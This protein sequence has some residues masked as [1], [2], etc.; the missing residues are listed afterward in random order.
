M[1]IARVF[2][3]TCFR[4]GRAAVA[5]AVCVL[6][7]CAMFAAP[8]RAQCT[9]GWLPGEGFPGISGGIVECS[10]MWDPD[11]PGPQQPRLV[12]AGIFAYAGNALG[13]G[14]AQW[15]P[16]TGVWSTLGPGFSP[17][18]GG[19]NPHAIAAGANGELYVGGWLVIPGGGVPYVARWTGSGWVQLGGA[20]DGLV[21]AVMVMP[22]GDVVVGG[23]FLNAGGVPARHVARW[24]GSTWSGLGAGV[25][26]RVSA[27]ASLPNGDIIVGGLFSN[28]GGVPASNIA[29]WNGVS[30]S[31]LGTGMV[32][33]N[34]NGG[35][36]VLALMVAAGGDIIAGGNFTTAGGAPTLNIAR[37]NG[38][39]WSQ[40]GVGLDGPVR[41]LLTLPNSHIIAGGTFV[42][43]VG[44]LPASNI[45]EWNPT[46]NSW[47]ALY[48]GV[49]STVYTVTKLPSGNVFAGGQ[50]DH[51]GIGVAV[52][53]A[54]WN[55]SA[56]SAMAGGMTYPSEVDCLLTA[57]SGDVLVGGAFVHAGNLDANRVASFNGVS[58]GAAQPAMNER[59]RAFCQRPNGDFIVGGEF[60]SAGNATV[61]RIARWNGSG[62]VDMNGGMT[63]FFQNTTPIVDAL[64][65][66]PNGDVYA[67]GDF[68]VAGGIL[69]YFLARWDGTS[70]STPGGGMDGI[71]RALLVMPNGDLIVGGDFTN[72]G[73]FGTP[74]SAPYLARWNGSVWS[75]VGG[76]TGGP[77]YALA[78]KPNGDIAVGGSFTSAGG[79]PGYNN[80][81]IW[82]GT[83]W[84]PLSSGTDTTVHALA[85]RANG[86]VIA[87]GDFTTAG[88]A[89]A[90]YIARYTGPG[91]GWTSLGSP[92]AGTNGSVLAL[93]MM[94]NGDVALGGQFY[95]VGGVGL[96]VFAGG[97]VSTYFARYAFGLDPLVIATQPVGGTICH[98]GTANLSVALAPG[99]YGAVSYQWWRY[100]NA[101]P[102]FSPI[103]NGVSGTGSIASGAQ[104]ASL[105]ISNFKAGD[106]GQY[107]CAITGPCGQTS[108]SIVTLTHCAADFNCSGGSPTVQD[109]FDF[110]AAWF[111]SSPSADFNGDT[112]IN[113]Q[114]I[115]DF[116]AAWFG[117]C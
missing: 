42:S 13:D 74:V 61:S 15:D 81:A 25:D 40:V 30:W 35:S 76:G 39:T 29:R 72:A 108:S 55:G 71:V 78:L 69:S 114:D 70:W 22:N 12:I 47:S 94:Q 14:I 117:G 67:G 23:D 75:A 111:A 83:L 52:G 66:M 59:V 79:S 26:H 92:G 100:T 107:Y 101:A 7:A 45:A 110:L 49:N 80:I 21:W 96:G 1:V 64:A 28:A 93:T 102:I 84:V 53:V 2:A 27:L 8:A 5:V 56:W 46:N 86:D 62:Y 90:L 58:W 77:V 104:T 116:L 65:A 97:A 20:L 9:S 19:L 98:N 3:L 4:A 91:G 48:L 103:I 24:N 18:G 73:V 85:V 87:G 33:G 16:A 6:L 32:G 113:V 88:G 36:T 95:H 44:G 106:T 50:F 54:Q 99:N 115:F 17:F 105:S 109:I 34:G 37:W 51:A 38:A 43:N 10:T 60:T 31:P 41:S 11:G 89:P 57:A 63:P 68:L 112:L 82:N